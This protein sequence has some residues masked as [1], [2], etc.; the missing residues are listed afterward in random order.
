MRG[1]TVDTTG[2]AGVAGVTDVP[3]AK[4]TAA[5]ARVLLLLLMLSQQACSTL[6]W[7]PHVFATRVSVLFWDQVCLFLEPR[8]PAGEDLGGG[9]D[10]L[11]APA[12]IVAADAG[13]ETGCAVTRGRQ[14]RWKGRRQW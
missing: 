5:V 7:L 13:A 10:V 14:V 6:R 11:A 8:V 3:G 12:G 4:N 2:A 1:S 9:G